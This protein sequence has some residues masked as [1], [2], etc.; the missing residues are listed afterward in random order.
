[1]SE[2]TAIT[3]SLPPKVIK[4]SL[5][6]ALLPITCQVM[7]FGNDSQRNDYLVNSKPEISTRLQVHVFQE[8]KSNAHYFQNAVIITF[9]V[10]P[11]PLQKC[12]VDE[13]IN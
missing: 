12:L 8:K 10:M 13:F 6:V 5:F 3:G 4:W 11:L 2:K 9:K 7:N 1:M